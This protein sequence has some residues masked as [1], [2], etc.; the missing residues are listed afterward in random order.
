MQSQCGNLQGF[1]NVPGKDEVIAGVANVG[2]YESTNGGASWTKMGTG[3]GSANIDHRPTCIVFDPTNSDIFW[4][5]GIHGTY[6]VYK[7]TDGGLTFK[8]L[9]KL[10]TA[11]NVKL[12]ILPIRSEQYSLRLG[13]SKN[14]CF[15]NRPMEAIPGPTSGTC[16]PAHH[17]PILWYSIH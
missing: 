17:S 5:A 4:E 15:P 9:G 7:T 2:L 1:W 13:T 3:A 14:K 10:T 11:D 8:L 12:R 6:G 16:H